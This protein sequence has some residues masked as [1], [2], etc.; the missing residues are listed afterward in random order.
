[1]TLVF[2]QDAYDRI[3]LILC[4]SLKLDAQLSG[5]K[6][7]ADTVQRYVRFEIVMDRKERSTERNAVGDTGRI[8]VREFKCRRCAICLCLIETEEL[9]EVNNKTL[10][11]M[12]EAKDVSPERKTH[13]NLFDSF[14]S[15]DMVRLHLL[16]AYRTFLKLRKQ[17]VARSQSRSSICIQEFRHT[18][19]LKRKVTQSGNMR[20]LVFVMR[21]GKM[22]RICKLRSPYI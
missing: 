17:I 5:L 6:R 12:H 1:M 16:P 7:L 18:N 14:F 21:V 3:Q 20:Q 8:N 9:F 19:T 4:T 10:V 13:N 11:E 22:L 2:K 15:H